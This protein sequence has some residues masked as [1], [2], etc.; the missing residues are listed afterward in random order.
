MN[1]LTDAKNSPAGPINVFLSREILTIW[2]QHLGLEIVEFL[3]GEQAVPGAT[4]LGQ[5]VCI[6]QKP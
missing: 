1:T 2:A 3:G 4:P 5:A 6:L